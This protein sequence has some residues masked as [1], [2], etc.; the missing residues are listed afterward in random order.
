MANARKR[1]KRRGGRQYRGYATPLPPV[2]ARLDQGRAR[3]GERDRTE[4]TVSKLLYKPF[5]LALGALAGAVGGYAFRHIW[6][7]LSDEDTAPK[8]M[9]ENGT[10]SEVLAAAALQGLIFAIVRA[11]V[12]RAG[13]TGFHRLTGRWPAS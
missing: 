3:E 13:A 2:S 8:A 5:G 6:R 11:A 1:P 12:D 4:A 9:D 10:W 7:A